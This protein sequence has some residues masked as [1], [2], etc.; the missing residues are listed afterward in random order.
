MSLESNINKYFVFNVTSYM[1]FVAPI[2]TLFFMAL[3]YSLSTIVLVTSSLFYLTWGVFTVPTGIFADIY[4]RKKALIIGS[5]FFLLGSLLIIL[6]KPMWVFVLSWFIIGLGAAF[7][8]GATSALLYDTLVKLK[9]KDE[10]KKIQ[11]KALF[12]VHMALGISALIGAY[13]YTINIR[14]PFVL[15]ACTSLICFIYSLALEESYVPKKKSSFLKKLKESA[16]FSWTDKKVRWI[17]AYDSVVITM[18]FVFFRNLIQPY[19]ISTGLGVASLGLLFA[20]YRF[21]SAIGSKI[22]HKFE[23]KLGEYNTLFVLPLLFS[24]IFFLLGKYVS[25]IGVGIMFAMFLVV[26]LYAPVVSGFINKHT[27]T[28]KRATV[29]SIKS[30]VQYSYQAFLIIALAIISEKF[31]MS[32]MLYTCSAILLLAGIVLIKTADRN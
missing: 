29:L 18:Y 24:I 25:F 2:F 3:G 22:S 9:R 12:Y 31:G 19:L 5:S 14:L 10:F 30:I 6:S 16:H 13:V 23:N 7:S 26:G 8:D 11:G 21:V 27:H 32:N 17:I 28:D 15:V 1:L 4:G 20:L